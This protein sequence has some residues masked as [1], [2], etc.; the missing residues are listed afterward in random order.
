MVNQ[1]PLQSNPD[2]KKLLDKWK[3]QI[4]MRQRNENLMVSL[5]QHNRVGISPLSSY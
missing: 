1:H 5:G 3:Y 2:Q 4:S